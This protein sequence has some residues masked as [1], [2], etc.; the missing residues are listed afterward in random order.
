M[1]IQPLMR[2]AAA[3]TNGKIRTKISASAK[4]KIDGISSISG[5]RKTSPAPPIVRIDWRFL[6]VW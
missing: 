2:A 3:V 6:S 1:P 4:M 5:S